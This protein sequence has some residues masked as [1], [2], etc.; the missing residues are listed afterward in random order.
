MNYTCYPNI[1]IEI[2]DY[3]LLISRLMLL[4]A[5]LILC[6]N[7]FATEIDASCFGFGENMIKN[8]AQGNWNESETDLSFGFNKTWSF[9]LPSEGWVHNTYQWVQNVPGFPTA[10]VSATYEQYV[11]GYNS[12]GTQYYYYNGDEI[13]TLGYTGSPDLVW[14]P[15][16][17]YGLPH[18][19]LGKT[20]TGT[21]NWAYGTYTVSGYVLSEGHVSTPLGTFE[22]LLVRYHYQTD[23]ISYYVYQWETGR[24]GIIAYANT[25]NE[26]MLYVLEEGT[27][28]AASDS[29]LEA[30]PLRAV[31]GPNPFRANLSIA[32]ES[33][34][35]ELVNVGIYD[36][37]GRLIARKEYSLQGGSELHLDL[38]HEFTSKAAGIYFISIKAETEKVI[39]K[40]TKL[41]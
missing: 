21:H 12:S 29:V 4:F 41:P 31:I 33:K 28:N 38:D 13:F 36:L 14:D 30:V 2:R 5:V 32:L 24:Y 18:N 39:H 10:N 1:L 25:L 11:L 17:P 22:A 26:G 15:P 6:V 37:R 23:V 34:R 8:Y 20:W 35:N 7:G 19:Y 3:R 9:S 40:V 27:P 16:V